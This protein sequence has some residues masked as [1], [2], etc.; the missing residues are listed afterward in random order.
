V[1]SPEVS[2][3]NMSLASFNQNTGV[4]DLHIDLT[5]LERGSVEQ[6]QWYRG[7]QVYAATLSGK[8]QV[9][10]SLDLQ[11]TPQLTYDVAKQ[12]LTATFGISLASVFGL[13]WLS[14]AKGDHV[15][16]VFA[17]FVDLGA[18]LALTEMEDVANLVNYDSVLAVVQPL[19]LVAHFAS[20]PGSAVKGDL[21]YGNSL[22]HSF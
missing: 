13:P 3:F 20:G 17:F 8:V 15:A 19:Q 21:Y 12:Q 10:A 11:I 14:F 7:L 18:G 6:Q 4:W 5:A 22:V 9:T 2:A 1:Q 16:N